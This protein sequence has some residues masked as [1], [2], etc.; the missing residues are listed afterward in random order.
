MRLRRS[1]K[2][3]LEEIFEEEEERERGDGKQRKEQKDYIEI[4]GG[5]GKVFTI[6]ID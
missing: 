1:D 4:Y 6:A 5:K 2:D 3:K